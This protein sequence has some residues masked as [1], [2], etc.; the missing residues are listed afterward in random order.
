[1]HAIAPRSSQRSVG[2][3]AAIIALSFVGIGL[4]WFSLSM[5]GRDSLRLIDGFVIRVSDASKSS[6][7]ATILQE[8]ILVRNGSGTFQLMHEYLPQLRELKVG[9]RVQVLADPDVRGFF[10]IWELRLGDSELLSYDQ[11]LDMHRQSNRFPALIALL[12]MVFALAL[13]KRYTRH[14]VRAEENAA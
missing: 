9:D 8:R 2:L 6:K 4:L 13:A 10:R 1:M 12:C 11:S 5:P 7:Y 14:Q 3:L